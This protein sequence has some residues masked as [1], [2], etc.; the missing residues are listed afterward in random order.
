MLICATPE[1]RSLL[2]ATGCAGEL[3]GWVG[4]LAGCCGWV[5]CV[6]EGMDATGAGTEAAAG[7]SA[8]EPPVAVGGGLVVDAP[9][10]GAEPP[11][12]AERLPNAGIEMSA[13][14]RKMRR[15]FFKF[16]LSLEFQSALLA[17]ASWRAERRQTSASILAA[18]GRQARCKRPPE[19]HVFYPG[20]SLIDALRRD[21]TVGGHADLRRR[22]VAA[23]SPRG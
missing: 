7:G 15:P 4:V 3:A 11:P 13:F 14:C 1:D 2:A 12:Q 19:M 18:R 22:R 17:G 8:T 23:M 5:V 10:P 9:A 20:T 6:V 16:V 21:A